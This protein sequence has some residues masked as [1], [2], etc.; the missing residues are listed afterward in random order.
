M[1][2][3]ASTI[4]RP[5]ISLKEAV[6]MEGTQSAV[7]TSEVVARITVRRRHTWV[8]L[9]G[10]QLTEDQARQVDAAEP[11]KLGDTVSI[12]GPVCEACEMPYREA[13]ES[14]PGEL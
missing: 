7:D 10:Y 3:A 6:P 8:L 1:S 4:R 13:A 11:V 14:C 12:G 5:N 2:A 9:L